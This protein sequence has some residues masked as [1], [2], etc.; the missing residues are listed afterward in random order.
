MCPN[1]HSSKQAKMKQMKPKHT[2]FGGPFPC[3][4]A[5]LCSAV[6]QPQLVPL[7]SQAFFTDSSSCGVTHRT[8]RVAAA[9]DELVWQRNTSPFLGTISIINVFLKSQ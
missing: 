7:D 8:L 6:H 9:E 3:D 2:Y 5:L 4:L 1:K